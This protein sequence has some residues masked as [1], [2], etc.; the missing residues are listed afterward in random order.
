[1][2]T[3]KIFFVITLFSISNLFSQEYS[4]KSPDGKIS[5]KIQ[6]NNRLQYS[7]SF[8]DQQLTDKCEIALNIDGKEYPTKDSRI[9]ESK[10]NV[11]DETFHPLVPLKSSVVLDNCNELVLTYDDN[12]DVVFRA[13]NNGFAYS[14]ITHFENP[15]KIFDEIV[16]VN[17][18]DDYSIL[19]PEEKGFI[20]H[21]ESSYKHLK[22]N[23]IND[24]QFCS[25]PALVECKNG[26]KIGLTESGL[27]DYPNL[28]YK[29]TSANG[30]A[31]TFPKVPLI[32][33]PTKSLDRDEKVVEE[34]DYIATT[35]GSRKFPWRIFMISEN[36]KEL[37][38]NQ[39]VYLLSDENVLKETSWIKPGKVAWDWWN[40]LNIYGVD[41]EA[42][43]NTKTYK[44]YIDFAS[45]YGVEYI[46]LDEG[47]SESTTNIIK[48]NAQI[49]INELVEY[50]KQKNVG[51]FLWVLWKP[52]NENL[53]AVLDQYKEWDVKGV[54]VDFMQRADQWMVNYYEK[55]LSESAKRHL[56]VDFHGAFKPAGFQRKYPNFISNEG[57]KGLE[58][59]KWSNEITPDHDCTLPFT[60]MLAGAMDYTPGAMINS[61][62]N[63]F[64][65]IYTKPMSQGT[66]AHQIAL[67]IIFE[68]PLQ[69]LADNPSNYYSNESSTQFISKIPTIW[70]DTYV[71]DGKVG[72]YVIMARKLNDIWYIGAITDWSERDIEIKLDFLDDNTYMAEYALDGINAN[73]YA[74]DIK[75]D[76]KKVK[77]GEYIKVHLAKGG[78]FAAIL[79][80]LN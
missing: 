18:A 63:N 70:D 78:G 37:I 8:N 52:L 25:L 5:V 27:S 41:F 74:S 80:P 38:S 24:E 4:L 10:L 61:E 21:F 40:A 33:E 26:V 13:Y 54:K 56:L 31:S 6:H 68:S 76:T 50:G 28:F 60:R 19:F 47:W 79:T 53:E 9:I 62:E 39:L 7:F 58:N 44:Y 45:K 48:G 72:D 14:I 64:R 1:M 16:K 35:K 32:I 75:F 2:N 12:I 22:I 77:K 51:I 46:V 66:R 3:Y 20:S 43:I 65:E 55:V 67:Y 23:E 29:G 57:V 49:N 11:I 59:G 73:K 36:D 30:L 17:F 42:G 34:A 71:I 69:M 15:I